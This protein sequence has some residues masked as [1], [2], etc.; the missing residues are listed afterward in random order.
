MINISARLAPL[1]VVLT[2]TGRSPEMLLNLLSPGRDSGEEGRSAAGTKEDGL[3][4]A[5]HGETSPRLK[6]TVLIPV[7]LPGV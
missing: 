4:P 7:K 6:L 5:D 1:F 2:L 3:R